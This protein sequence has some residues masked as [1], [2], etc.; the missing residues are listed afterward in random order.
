MIS[1]FLTGL[2]GQHTH[3]AGRKDFGDFGEPLV[4][5]FPAAWCSEHDCKLNRNSK[6]SRCFKK[7]KKTNELYRKLSPTIANDVCAKGELSP[8]IALIIDAKIT[9]IADLIRSTTS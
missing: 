1:S 3:E 9:S 8:R 7:I 5:G 2:P 6:K 4:S